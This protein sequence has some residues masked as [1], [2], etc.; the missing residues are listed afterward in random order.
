MQSFSMWPPPSAP[1]WQ[2]PPNTGGRGSG[3]PGPIKRETRFGSPYKSNSTRGEFARGCPTKSPLNKAKPRARVDPIVN[4]AANVD[5]TCH[6]VWQCNACSAT[7]A[8]KNN[9]MKHRKLHLGE[10]SHRCEVCGK[11]FNVKSNL[12]GHMALHTQQKQYSCPICHAKASYKQS[13][14]FHLKNKHGIRDETKLSQII[15]SVKFVSVIAREE[16]DRK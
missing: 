5:G 7:F 4:M 1:M 2:Q 8:N 15:S 10:Y 3:L 12:E 9:F 16:M 14:K 6:Q 13:F 11:G